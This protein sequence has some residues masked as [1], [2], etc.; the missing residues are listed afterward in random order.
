MWSD[1]VA[2]VPGKSQARQMDQGLHEARAGI[3]VLTPAYLAGRFW[4]ERGLGALLHKDTL[5]P[6]LHGVTFE[7]VKEYSGIPHRTP[8]GVASPCRKGRLGRSYHGIV[9]PQNIPYCGVTDRSGESKSRLISPRC[10]SSPMVRIS[11]HSSER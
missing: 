3:A 10:N 11:C 7:Q 5:I 1:E 6:V 2:I 4:T 8:V 9:L